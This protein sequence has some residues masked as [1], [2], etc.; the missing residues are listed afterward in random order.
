[1]EREDTFDTVTGSDAAECECFTDSASVLSDNNTSESLD[2]F[3]GTL[4]DLCVDLDGV[5][6][7]EFGHVFFALLLFQLC[8]NL[9]HDIL[10]Q[11]FFM[12]NLLISYSAD[13]AAVQP[14]SVLTAPCAT[15]RFQHGYR[16]AELP[17]Q[18]Y[19]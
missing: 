11:V 18:P 4:N 16:K 10:R 13:Q 17:A 2:T 7:I 6:D 19:L 14:F 1:M 3:I 5:T 9:V 15:W 12:L 8:N